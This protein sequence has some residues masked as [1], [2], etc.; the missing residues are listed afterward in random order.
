M[1]RIPVH[2]G[3]KGLRPLEGWRK[4][5]VLVPAYAIGLAVSL[6]PHEVAW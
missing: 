4:A 2:V 6:F 3:E 5:Y 1:K